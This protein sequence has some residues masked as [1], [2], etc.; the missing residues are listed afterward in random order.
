[1]IGVVAAGSGFGDGSRR[2]HWP[3]G[4][5]GAHSIETVR[6]ALDRA[7]PWVDLVSVSEQQRTRLLQIVDRHEPE[8]RQLDS[9]RRRLVDEFAS[10]LKVGRVNATDTDRL[11]AET[12]ELGG[13]AIDELVALV[14]EAVQVLTPEQR[15]RLAALWLAR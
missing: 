15:A 2:V 6:Q 11:R 14:T 8:L 10:A 5:T 13:R 3:R 7:S 12:R 4:R 9:E 1:M